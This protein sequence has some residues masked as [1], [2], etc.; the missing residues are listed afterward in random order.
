V[1]RRLAPIALLLSQESSLSLHLLVYSTTASIPESLHA[2][3]KREREQEQAK[4]LARIKR[5][6]ESSG[7]CKHLHSD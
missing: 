1:K 2:Q 6:E 3:E 5:G 7:E 4:E